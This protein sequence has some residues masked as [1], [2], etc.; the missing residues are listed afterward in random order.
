MAGRLC[1]EPRKRQ[2]QL[3]LQLS[4]CSP[5][6]IGPLPYEAL[7]FPATRVVSDV[8]GQN[9]TN[10]PGR[11]E[12]NATDYLDLTLARIEALNYLEI[13]ATNS[14]GGNNGG[15]LSAPFMDVFLRSTNG[16][17]AITNLIAPTVARPEGTIE[18]WSGR[19]T[20]E[21]AGVT[22]EYHVLFVDSQLSPTFPPR[23][24]DTVLISTNIDGSGPGSL[25]IND[26]LTILRNSLFD[27]AS[28]TIAS[29][30]AWADR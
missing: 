1:W 5:L 23:I 13:N 20:N 14:Y 15:V 22:N 6:P 10:L 26:V 19:W 24:Q 17:L 25:I 16:V 28:I 27:A 21:V 9:V 30:S 12:I 7:F 11:I 8:V 18:V 3:P 4:I 2:R 29:N